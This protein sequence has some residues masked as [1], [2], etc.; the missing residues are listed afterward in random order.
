MAGT[1]RKRIG[2]YE[3][4]RE[5]GQG[6]M[7]VVHLARQPA[8]DRQVVIKTLRRSLAE[9][10]VLEERFRREAQAAAGVH[11]QNV[12]AVHDCF[13]WRG[14]QFIAQEYVPGEDLSSVLRI[15]RRIDP[16]VAGLMA[17]E[18]ARGL[19][20]IHAQDVVHRDL[21]PGNVLVGRGGQAKI[22]D[23]GIALAARNP[24]LT[25]VGLTVGTPAYMSPEQHRGERADPTQR[26]LRVRSAALRDADRRAALF[27]A[28]DGEGGYRRWLR[29]MEA[30]R[31]T[32][33]RASSHPRLRT[34][35]RAG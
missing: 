8:L 9:D 14:E 16:H 4:L 19:E 34:C 18:L 1:T 30:G 3:V 5:L 31:Y 10:A 11:H 23:F 33:R 15:V 13:S 20:E 6:G 32:A 28:S 25:Q 7:G 2:S 26:P 21:K 12:V 22:A 27:P 24:A 29:K 17:L 35:H